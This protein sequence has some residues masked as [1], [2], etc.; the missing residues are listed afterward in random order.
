MASDLIK[1]MKI[2]A[3][4]MKTQGIRLRVVSENLANA[5][6]TAANPGANPYRR[7]VVSF[8]NALDRELG[9]ETVRLRKITTD[10]SPFTIR[11]EPGH[12]AANSEGYV[13]Y[14]NVNPL[15]EMTDMR[16]A[17]RTYEANLNVMETSRSM[18]QRTIDML[19]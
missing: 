16:E 10:K 12:P 6:S 18:V 4:G 8:K 14:P 7:K 5:Q 19:R 3:A 13:A 11:Y 2:S 15:L 17:Q 9:V 1:S